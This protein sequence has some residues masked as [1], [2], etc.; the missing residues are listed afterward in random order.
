LSTLAASAAAGRQVDR[1]VGLWS[2]PLFGAFLAAALPPFGLLPA[3]V[4]PAALFLALLRGAGFWPGL[5]TAWL[6]GLGFHLAGLYWVGIAF[7]AE[8]E[9]FGALAVP[10]VMGLAAILALLAAVPLALLACRHWRSPLAASVLF[11]ALWCLGELARGRYGV[12]FPWNPLALS[13]AATDTSLQL[14]ALFGTTGSSFVLAWL[15]A[16]VGLVGRSAV[17]RGGGAPGEGWVLPTLCA[18]LIVV[19]VAGFG[20]WRLAADL[21]VATTGDVQ[22][23]IVQGN[24][25]QHHKWNPELRRRWFERHLAL[26]GQ[27]AGQAPDVVIWPESSVPYP[28]ESMAEVRELIGSVVRPGGHVI[29]GSD[30]YD[31]SVEPPRLHNSVYTLAAGGEILARYDKVDLVPF[32]EFLPFRAIFG[33]LGLEALAVGSVDF[34]AGDGRTTVAVDGLPSFSPLVCYEAA[35]A[36]RATDGTERARWLVNVTNDGWFGI[37]SGPHQHAGMARMRAVE[38]GL[39]LV[40]A[41]NTGISLVTDARGRVL[42]SLPLGEMGTLDHALPPALATAPAAAQLPWLPAALTG[43]LLLGAAWRERRRPDDVRGEFDR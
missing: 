21:P 11:A 29:L 28:L 26:S 17:R 6:F 39:P 8:A 34:T 35:F 9:R 15:A 31:P 41:A 13:L 24:I 2:M 32:G 3:V 20:R 40:R 4:A 23:R 14:V 10:G 38:T 42:A 18:L 1:R 22:V 33:R 25:A 19:G 30:F 43:L 36:A 27:P 16:L 12:Q 5:V 37:S 7:F